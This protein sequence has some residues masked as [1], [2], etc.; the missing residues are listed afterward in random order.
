MST[1]TCNRHYLQKAAVI[2]SAAISHSLISFSCCRQ[3]ASGAD[4]VNKRRFS[5]WQF[6]TVKLSWQHL[7]WLCSSKITKSSESGE[8]WKYRW[9]WRY[10]NAPLTQCQSIQPFQQNVEHITV[11]NLPQIIIVQKKITRDVKTVYFSEPVAD[12][13]K[14]VFTSYGKAYCERDN[15]HRSLRARYQSIAVASG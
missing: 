5:V 2:C 4:V 8:S 1:K 15:C 3:F 13:P 7:L 6:V 10:T 12:L 11:H 14:P 9:V